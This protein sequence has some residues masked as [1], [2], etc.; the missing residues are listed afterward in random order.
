MIVD[1]SLKEAM[2]EFAHDQTI[3]ALNLENK[4]DEIKEFLAQ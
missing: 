4:I 1:V 2:I 3:I